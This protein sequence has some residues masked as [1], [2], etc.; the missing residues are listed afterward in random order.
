MTS[1]K[2]HPRLV[3]RTNSL[4][5][6]IYYVVLLCLVNKFREIVHH[7]AL[8]CGGEI[9]NYSI[10]IDFSSITEFA[11]LTYS[12][13]A[14]LPWMKAASYMLNLLL[15]VFSTSWSLS[16]TSSFIICV[17]LRFGVYIHSH[18]LEIFS[19]RSLLYAREIQFHFTWGERRRNVSLMAKYFYYGDAL[20]STRAIT[21]VRIWWL[22]FFL[23][24]F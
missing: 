6:N 23:V 13:P 15:F 3:L 11:Y 24:D 9:R 7:F 8:S 5:N 14:S 10:R 21:K 19:H 18:R 4:K 1:L 12:S 22:F 2:I 16:Q 20:R 17:I